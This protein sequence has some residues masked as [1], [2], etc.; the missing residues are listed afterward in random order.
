MKRKKRAKK[1][2]WFFGG[3]LLSF[4]VFWWWQPWC[5]DLIPKLPSMPL[6][7]VDPETTK[8]FAKGTRILV[9]TAHPDDEGFYGGAL[10]ARLHKS[11]AVIHFVVCTDGDKAYYGPFTNA[12]E[13]RSVR[14]REM[15]EVATSLE[16]QGVEFLGFPDGRLVVSD[17]LVK[18]IASSITAFKPDYLL[19]FD[20]DYP[21]RFSHSDHRRAGEAAVRAANDSSFKGWL[22]LFQTG[23]TTY[24]FP[25]TDWWPQKDKLMM[26]HK[27]QFNGTRLEQVRALVR[28]TA[29][30]EGKSLGVSLAE[31]FRATKLH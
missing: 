24:R 9:V 4:V 19:T 3:L 8:L 13:N 1:V 6:K 20:P 21:V 29:E 17:A 31:G 15:R 30:Q 23:A 2:L 7:P 18:D 26:I 10:L 14:Q 16:A 5:F 28:N 25:A 22:L 27:S 12:K 11:E